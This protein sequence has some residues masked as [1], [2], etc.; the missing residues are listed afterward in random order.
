MQVAVAVAVITQRVVAVVVAVVVTAETIVLSKAQMEPLTRVAVQVAVIALALMA[1]QV[2]SSCAT[3]IHAQS[4]SA[5]DLLAQNHL[6]QVDT[7]EQQL[8]LAQ[9]MCRGHRIG[10][11]LWHITHF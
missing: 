5:Q 4:L 10:Q 8:P 11:Y 1:V 6:R 2:L 9:A 7:N 3:Q